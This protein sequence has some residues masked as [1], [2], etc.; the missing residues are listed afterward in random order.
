M[1]GLPP[2]PL[3]L[4][5]LFAAPFVLCLGVFNPFFDRAPLVR[6]GDFEISGGWISFASITLRFALTLSAALILVATTGMTAVCV[7]LTRLKVPRLFAV[8]LLLL[9]RYLFVLM[10]KGLRMVRAHAL[11]SGGGRLTPRV[12]GSLVGQ[13]LLRALDRA[14]RLHTAMLCRGFA[15][16]FQLSRRMRFT[17]TDL[18]FLL[19]WIAFFAAARCYNLPRLLGQAALGSFR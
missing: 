7:A 8:Q 3:F 19:G 10:D 4:R 1:G 18:F 16:E 15:G 6:L 14:H 12:F 5:L 11:R 2:R 13:L 9:Y 17:F